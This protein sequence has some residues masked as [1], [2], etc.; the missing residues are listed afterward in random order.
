METTLSYI[1][2]G[3]LKVEIRFAMDGTRERKIAKAMRKLID[4]LKELKHKAQRNEYGVPIPIRKAS[5]VSIEYMD[6]DKRLHAK[7]SFA[8]GR[9]EE[10]LVGATIKTF[11]DEVDELNQ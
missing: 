6:T 10:D 2:E 5:M 4:E 7:V 3:V 1:D 8:A 11:I 9:G